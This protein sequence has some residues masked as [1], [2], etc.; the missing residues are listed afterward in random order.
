MS[1]N[2]KAD[3]GPASR[4][5][6]SNRQ[7]VVREDVRQQTHLQAAQ[8]LARQPRVMASAVHP[9]G[10][11]PYVVR[12]ALPGGGIVYSSMLQP[13]SSNMGLSGMPYNP[14]FAYHLPPPALCDARSS[15]FQ[16]IASS[17]PTARLIQTTSSA[18]QATIPHRLQP[19]IPMAEMTAHSVGAIAQ[20]ESAILEVMEAHRRKTFVYRDYAK[21]HE[22]IKPLPYERSNQEQTFPVILYRI[23]SNS[24]C[25]DCIS[26]LPH[27]RA[28]KIYKSQGVEEQVLPLYFRSAKMT[29][30][31]RQV[32]NGYS[33]KHACGGLWWY[34]HTSTVVFANSNATTY[35]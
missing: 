24:E 11:H 29:S 5:G 26:W 3:G 33:V 17:I 4:Q 35:R 15:L 7:Q 13:T 8:L 16:P 32:S 2:S 27:G 14:T 22:S 19:T 6:S 34:V 25:K 9:Y 12:P 28:F 21:E 31:M 23:L 20:P 1:V 10:S 18:H 30:F